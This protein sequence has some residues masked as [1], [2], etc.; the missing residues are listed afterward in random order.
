MDLCNICYVCEKYF[1]NGICE[2]CNKLTNK[3]SDL[4]RHLDWLNYSLCTMQTELA[5]PDKYIL[6]YI[7]KEFIRQK[8]FI[9]RHD[10]CQ[11]ELNKLYADLIKIQDFADIKIHNDLFTCECCDDSIPGDE[12][13]IGNVCEK[14]FKMNEFK[15]MNINISK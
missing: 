7:K 12:V 4:E 15:Y 9:I 8:E 14:C 11:Q 2:K 1:T 5:Q 3:I 6:N 10:E 13:Y